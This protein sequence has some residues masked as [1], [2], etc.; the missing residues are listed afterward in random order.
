MTEDIFGVEKLS[1]DLKKSAGLL[2]ASQARYL[3]DYYYKIQDDRIR[4]AGQVRSSEAEEPIDWIDFVYRQLFAL[5]NRIKSALGIYSLSTELGHWSRSITGIGPVLSAGLLAHIDITK[6][7]HP[8]SLWRLAGL[9]PTSKWIGSDAAKKLVAEKIASRGKVSKQEIRDLAVMSNRN[10]VLLEKMAVSYNKKDGDTKV[11]TTNLAKALARRPWNAQ[12]KVIQ[13]KIGESFVK[14]QGKKG[15]KFYGEFYAQRRALE[16]ARNDDMLNEVEALAKAK[17][18]G[19]STD[20]YKSYSLGKFPPGH[21]YSRSKRWV[22]KL[23]LSHYH[24]VAHEIHYGKPPERPWIITHG[25][26]SDFIP[27][28]NWR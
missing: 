27:P 1:D 28:P 20:A 12:L 11:T 13:W 24:H 18:V 5:E 23:F 16:E 4:A 8:G 19:K 6:T 15:G 2:T 10:P 7:A 22:V 9:D 26:H 21:L 3:V 14:V 17:T 25:G